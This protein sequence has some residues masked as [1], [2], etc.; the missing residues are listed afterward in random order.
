MPKVY[1]KKNKCGGILLS[2][3][4]TN[5]KSSVVMTVW[6]LHNNEQ[7]I[8]CP[9]IYGTEQGICKLIQTY[10]DNFLNKREKATQQS[11]DDLFNKQCGPNS[12]YMHKEINL[13][14]YPILFI[15]IISECMTNLNTNPKTLKS[16]QK[17]GR[18]STQLTHRANFYDLELEKCHRNSTRKNYPYRNIQI[19]K[20]N[21]YQKD[22]ISLFKKQG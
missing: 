8:N 19:K 13:D 11:K 4:K 16:L 3:F 17:N 12:I 20:K 7:H 1:L 22:I 21:L 14:P 10:V 2:D 5:F 6:Y 18:R 9:F 15:K